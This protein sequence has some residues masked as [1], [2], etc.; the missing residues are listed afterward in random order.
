M[1]F[2]VW[3]DFRNPRRWFLPWGELYQ[4]LLDQAVWAEQLG[5]DS[6]WVS[7]HHFT[8]DG[9]LP[10]LV[11]ML[12]VL[13]TRTSTARLGT[14]VYLAPL[15][16]PLRLAEDIAVVDQLSGG[17]VEIGI[18]PGYRPSEFAVLGIP[19]RERGA[20]TDEAIELL[21]LA[22]RGEP[23]SY[24][25]RHFSFDDVVVT[26]PP[27][28]PGGP[29]LWVGGSSVH[30]AARA[31]RHG[32]GFMPD[33]GAT[34]DV[35]ERYRSGFRGSGAP[36]VATNRVLFAA[37]SREEAWALCGPHVLEQFNTYRRWFAEAEDRDS[38]GAEVED[39]AALSPEHY[40]VGTP[41]D[42]IAAIERSRARYGYEELVFWARPPGMPLEVANRS[43]ELIARHV[44]PEFPS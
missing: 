27:V 11:A 35:Y 12:A 3:Y 22:W 33:S 10:S 40:F 42:L 5:Y 29:Q 2:G 19:R 32:C 36:R 4:G 38:H 37:S 20:R 44:L 18:A 23:F 17:R 26:P 15:H 34:D 31:A 30:A 1:R 43:L 8:E 7:E 28:R 13:G 14:A 16:H 21:R 25:G 24:E 9:Y 39:V 6:I 41:D